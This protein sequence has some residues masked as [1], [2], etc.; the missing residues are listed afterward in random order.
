VGGDPTIDPSHPSAQFYAWVPAD[1][2]ASQEIRGNIDQAN[3]IESGLRTCRSANAAILSHD[4]PKTYHQAV[5]S[6]DSENWEG[7]ISNELGNM[8]RLHVWSVANVSGKDIRP[9]TTTWVFKKKTDQDG[10]LAKYKARLC[11]CVFNQQEGINY[12]DI[13]SLTGRLTSLQIMLTIGALNQFEVHQMDVRCAFLNGTPEEDLYIH[14][15]LGLNAPPKTILKLHKALFGLKQSPRCWQKDL[16]TALKSIGLKTTYSDLCLYVSADKSKPFF[17]FVHVDNLLF[18]GSWPVLFKEKIS[19]IFDME[20]LGIAKYALG[21]RINQLGGSIALVQ[22]KY[23]NNMLD[24]FNIT[25]NQTR[26]T[27]IPLPS[28]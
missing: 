9:L 6:F 24:E 25:N 10:N 5:S 27:M 4:D 12:Q 13:F 19:A 1:K 23:M 7:A 20:N 14:A 16:T 3:I 21:I 15:P 2:P 18:G 26:T 11:V 22:D 28:N 8:D 17:L